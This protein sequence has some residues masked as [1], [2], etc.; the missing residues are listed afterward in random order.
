ME[1]KDILFA[2][3]RSVVCGEALQPDFAAACTQE[4]IAAVIKLAD[5]HDLAHLV[6]H[7]MEKINIPPCDVPVKQ[8]KTMA[9]YRY[10]QL[11]YELERIRRTLE[12]AQIPF[13]PLK[14][15]VLRQYYPE[16][17]MR[18]SGDI[19]ILVHEEDLSRATDYLVS[20]LG[21][22][23]KGRAYHDVVFH[24]PSGVT[25]ELH[26][27]LAEE[28][29]FPGALKI[30]SAVWDYT[31]PV[32]DC[33]YE[34]QLTWEMF[35][36]H[37]IFHM[38]SHFCA[39][40]CG[41]RFILDHFIIK[42]KLHIDSTKCRKML[43]E[44]GLAVFAESMDKLSE[45]WFS[46]NEHTAHTK[47]I[48]DFILSGGVF[49]STENHAAVKQAKQGGKLQSV[50]SKIILPYDQLKGLYPILTKKKWLTPVFQI[51]RWFRLLDPARWNRSVNFLKSSMNTHEERAKA[52][53]TLMQELEIQ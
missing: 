32:P 40:G 17:W 24:A 5:K 16:P 14:G 33:L 36:F 4:T 7:A 15:S 37:H 41:I 19:D 23:N 45:V 49:G 31:K 2:L 13:I 10:A 52:M 42:T 46:G 22:T 1:T 11:D 43:Q 47:R 28:S 51:I 53:S 29:S 30:T 25:L 6:V 26:F 38:A 18:T 20:E 39:G 50:L 27:I 34:K 3:L 12:K 9:I 21:Y 35:Y 44:S 8:K 48:E